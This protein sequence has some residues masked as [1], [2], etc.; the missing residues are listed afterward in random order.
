MQTLNLQSACEQL[1]QEHS[2]QLFNAIA[3]QQPLAPQVAHLHS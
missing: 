1:D 3:Y 2:S